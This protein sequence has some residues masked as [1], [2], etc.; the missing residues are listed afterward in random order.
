[1]S[2]SPIV[3]QLKIIAQCYHSLAAHHDALA[4]HYANAEKMMPAGTAAEEKPAKPPKE[5]A[6]KADKPKPEAP[7]AEPPATVSP[8]AI[9]ADLKVK[10]VALANKDRAKAVAILG[11]VGAKNFSTVPVEKHAEILRKFDDAL[12][13]KPADDDPLA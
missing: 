9:A 7:P 10:I 4:A 5:K 1:M 13:P 8:E 2:D 11:T 12:N 6:T 3:N